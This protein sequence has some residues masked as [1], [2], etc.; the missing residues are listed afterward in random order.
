MNNYYAK[1][2]ASMK[3]CVIDLSASI[4]NNR[5]A[6]ALTDPK[7]SEKLAIP[8]VATDL[9]QAVA[10]YQEENG[11]AKDAITLFVNYYIAQLKTNAI[12]EEKVYQIAKG[13]DNY[14]YGNSFILKLVRQLGAGPAHM[15]I[16]NIGKDRFTEALIHRFISDSNSFMATIF[17]GDRDHDTDYMFKYARERN[18]REYKKQ[19][20]CKYTSLFNNLPKPIC[21]YVTSPTFAAYLFDEY[22]KLDL[23]R[24]FSA[25]E[26]FGFDKEDNTPCEAVSAM[27]EFYGAEND[28]YVDAAKAD[29]LK[30]WLPIL[31]HRKLF[32]ICQ[33]LHKQGREALLDEFFDF[34]IENRTVQLAKEAYESW[35]KNN[36]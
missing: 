29:R 3:D 35:T 20:I 19:L 7:Y 4:D 6:E 11:D 24:P 12:D 26:Q 25:L 16:I 21:F 15:L 13:M 10:E 34:N 23:I 36:R 9:I 28:I 14:R 22:L 30:D 27:L 17:I 18:L 5:L 31:D 32:S 8:E 1:M 33:I 2:P